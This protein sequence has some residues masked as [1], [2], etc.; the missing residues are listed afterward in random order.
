MTQRKPRY[1]SPCT[2]SAL[3]S[4][5]SV[6]RPALLFFARLPGIEV[7]FDFEI[8]GELDDRFDNHW[9]DHIIKAVR[10][11][12]IEEEGPA[13]PGSLDN[14]P[15]AVHLGID[16]FGFVSSVGIVHLGGKVNAGLLDI[17]LRQGKKF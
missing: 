15:G 14:V 3:N 13:F 11:Q 2:K 1:A 17:Y 8:Q 16:G 5:L 10:A 9:I 6:I 7:V 12:S 4:T